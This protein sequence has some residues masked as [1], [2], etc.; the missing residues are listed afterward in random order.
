M[1]R[2]I[3]ITLV[4]SFANVGEAQAECLPTAQAVRSAHPGAYPLWS[5]RVRGHKGDRCWYA[6]G[7][8]NKEARHD[9]PHKASDVDVPVKS[10]DAP[11]QAKRPSVRPWPEPKMTPQAIIDQAFSEFRDKPDADSRIEDSIL[12]AYWERFVRESR[13]KSSIVMAHVQSMK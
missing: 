7:W 1:R 3:S 13:R 5:N 9:A 12:I 11:A 2:L 8:R 4:V 6:E 10:D